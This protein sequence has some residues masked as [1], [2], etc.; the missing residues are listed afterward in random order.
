MT[1]QIECANF[2]LDTIDIIEGLRT[3]VGYP[4][5]KCGELSE[6]PRNVLKSYPPSEEMP[7]NQDFLNVHNVLK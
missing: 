1:G 7:E 4:N 6:M 3:R 2:M 5:K